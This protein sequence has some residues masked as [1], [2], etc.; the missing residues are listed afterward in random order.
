MKRLAVIL[1]A[2]MLVGCIHSGVSPKPTEEAARKYSAAA[3]TLSDFSMKIV[4][5]YRSKDSPIPDDF[6]AD[7][8]FAILRDIY[9]DRGRVES[10]ASD[11]RVSV[12]PLDGG[13]SVMLCDPAGSRKIMEDFSCHV[14]RVELR[15]WESDVAA[16]CVFEDNWKS[17]CGP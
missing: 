2:G 7:K 10:I 1:L 17:Y 5:Y 4:A 13:Y 16:A 12:R 8:F 14:D 3:V 9:P 11:F 6:D 15:S